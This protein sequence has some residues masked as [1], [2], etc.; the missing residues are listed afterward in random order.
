[1]E[2]LKEWIKAEAKRL[3]FSFIGVSAPLKTPHFENYLRWA[4][5]SH[6][7]SLDYLA[8]D[9]VINGRRN[10]KSLL[11]G[12]TSVIVAG[13]HYQPTIGLSD[14][15]SI[16]A[17][18]TG[19][20]AS[21]AT[22]P[23]YHTKIRGML[24]ELVHNI[25]GSLDNK[26]KYKIYIDSGPVMEKDFA[27]QAGLGW[28]G[29]NSLLISPQFGSYCLLGCL[30]TDVEIDPDIPLDGDICTGCSACIDACPTQCIFSDRTLNVEK[31][32]SYLTIEQ[33]RNLPDVLG[34][35]NYSWIF[36]CDICQLVCPVNLRISGNTSGMPADPVQSIIPQSLILESELT[37]NQ[38]EFFRRYSNTPVFHIGYDR[39][40]ENLQVALSAKKI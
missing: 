13:I 28:I 31:C 40:R 9:Y 23:D 39:F 17:G 21:Y 35:R 22:L 1:M 29:R 37:L 16:K 5:G 18:T 10:P 33:D 38:D 27:F 4:E 3:G 6:Q 7:I 19:L 14:I 36:G 15:S 20:I 30:F 24:K 2:N 8:K 25:E 34:Q 32:I 12:V 11:D 26:I